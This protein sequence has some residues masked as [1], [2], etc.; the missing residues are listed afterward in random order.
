M[1]DGYA[2][3]FVFETAFLILLA[4]GLGLA[5]ERPLVIVGVMA[6]AWLVVSL[7]ELAAWRASRPVPPPLVEPHPVE[8]LHGWDVAQI[9][10][11]QAPPPDVE[12]TTALPPAADEEAAPRRRLFRRRKEEH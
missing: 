4:V 3:R 8:E 10:A 5:D 7:L 6:A 9:I 12:L 11:P 1:G 2:G